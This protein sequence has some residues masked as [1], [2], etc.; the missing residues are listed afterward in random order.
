MDSAAQQHCGIHIVIIPIFTEQRNY[1][2]GKKH[3]ASQVS[4]L[5]NNVD[6]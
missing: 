6:L 4:E 2:R 3:T 1:E 5:G